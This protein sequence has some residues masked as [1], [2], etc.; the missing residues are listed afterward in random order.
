M[1]AAVTAILLGSQCGSLQSVY[2]RAPD[3]GL[4]G[5]EIAVLAALTRLTSLS[6]CV[7]LINCRTVACFMC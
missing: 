7:E 2:L 5:V 3:V 4:A 6:V 1:P